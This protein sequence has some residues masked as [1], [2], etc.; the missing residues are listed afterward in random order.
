MLKELAC[1]SYDEDDCSV[2]VECSN[3][4]FLIDSIHSSS[5]RI[6]DWSFTDVSNWLLTRNPKLSENFALTLKCE[7]IKRSVLP[8]VLLL[9]FVVA[10]LLLY[11]MWYKKYIQYK[12]L[13]LSKKVKSA[14]AS[15]AIESVGI[16]SVILICSIWG[17]LT[18]CTYRMWRDLTNFTN[19]YW[20]FISWD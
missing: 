5:T 1:L 11:L 10:F 19:K 3:C 6:T 4:R 18:M 9:L 15:T 16:C 2:L 14:W 12:Y 17:W 8:P 20:F 13:D 7:S